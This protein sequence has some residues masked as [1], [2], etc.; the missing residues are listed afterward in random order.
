MKK[1]K[2]NPDEKYVVKRSKTGLGLFARLPIKK[3]EQIIE[4]VG[5]LIDNDEADRIANRYIFEVNDGWNINGAMRSNK[6]RY[7]NHSCDPNAETDVKGL[8]V[9]VNAI[10]DIKEGEE[11]AYDY[12][13]EYF[14]EFIRPVGCKCPRCLS[15]EKTRATT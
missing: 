9:F 12:G 11:I 15:R 3:G 5:D 14:D 10:K 8:R 4:Y 13:E 2:I 7:I 1:K 6:A